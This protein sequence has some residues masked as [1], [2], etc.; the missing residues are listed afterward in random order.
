MMRGLLKKGLLL[1]RE[2][3]VEIPGC[4]LDEDID[5]ILDALERYIAEIE[6]FNP[7]YKL[8]G[9]SD[10]KE[11]I[12][13]HILDSLS[14][15]GVINRFASLRAA[16]SC[17]G[18]KVNIADAGSGAGLPGI[19]LALSMPR[20]HFT[21]IER[22]GRRAGFLHNTLAAL[23][24]QNATVEEQEIEK[25]APNRFNIITF[26]AFKPLDRHTLKSLF[27]LLTPDGVLT[28]Y[29]GRKNAI[30]K[31]IAL[32]KASFKIS[33]FRESEAVAGWETIRVFTPF[34]EEERHIV[35]IPRGSAP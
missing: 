24:V 4:V 5:R 14:G 8:V 21:L 10:R 17:A 19:P 23:G 33:P 20:C 13:K 1:L 7:A 11:L 34:L 15:V 35:V 6:L 18:I 27:R 29:K 31:E 22:M 9:T 32:L 12:I 26:R 28:A 30:E 2:N 3:G 16:H 25:A